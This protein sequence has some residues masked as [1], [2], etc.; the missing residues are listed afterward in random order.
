ME[1]RLGCRNF[2][3]GAPSA[4]Y[5]AEAGFSQQWIIAPRGL[6]VYGGCVVQEERTTLGDERVDTQGSLSDNRRKAIA[7]CGLQG[8]S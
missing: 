6:L 3:G 5:T 8:V 4:N 1:V 2:Y 7:E